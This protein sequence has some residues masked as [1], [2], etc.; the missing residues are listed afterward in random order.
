MGSACRSPILQTVLVNS[1]QNYLSFLRS[2]TLSC[3]PNQSARL[4]NKMKSKTIWSFCCLWAM[5][6]HHSCLLVT[7]C[8]I[9]ARIGLIF[10]RAVDMVLCFGFRMRIISTTVMFCLLLSS[11]AQSQGQ[12]SFLV[13]HTILPARGLGGTRSGGDGGTGPGQLT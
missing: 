2:T 7:G 12:F 1:M 3:S 6:I 11:A 13:S 8:P 9:L 4:Q 5:L 10:F